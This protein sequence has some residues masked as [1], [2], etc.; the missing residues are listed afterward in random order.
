L[1]V[2]VAALRKILG[3]KK[4]EHRFIVTVPGKGYKFVADVA[5]SSGKENEI[6]IDSH[7][8]SRVLIEED[9]VE[10]SD[11]E[12][13]AEKIISP[14]PTLEKHKSGK[15]VS[16]T[17]LF[18]LCSSLVLVLTAFLAGIWFWE[19]GKPTERKQFSIVKLTSSGK[20][21][22]AAMTPDGK[23]AVFSQTEEAGESLWLRH[24]DTGSQTQ[25]VPAKAIKYV[26]LTTSPDGNLI[27]A[28]V[29]GGGMTDPQIWRLP[30]L[31]DSVEEMKEIKTGATVSLSPDGN[32]FAFTESRSALKE[33]HFGIADSN[34][35]NKRILI[36]GADDRRSFPNFGLTPVAWSPDGG[37]IA[38][39]V[40]EKLADGAKKSGILLVNPVDGGERFVSEKRWDYIA[41]LAWVD[42]DTLA[43]TAYQM[44]SR[45]GQIWILL[46]HFR[47]VTGFRKVISERFQFV[48]RRS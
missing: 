21:S 19:S 15:P 7:E 31:G 13:R 16:K 5:D 24:V 28:T 18:I 1:T 40:E 25:I 26:G 9:V 10:R 2:H 8:F 22:N 27:Y 44:N 38:C 35:T 46:P 30:L 29:F 47:Q 37:E 34:G 32:R 45:Q 4:C 6:I 20:I 42:G 39:I 12:I 33:T 17:S 36:R 48:G 14:H 3:E 23:Y 43:F 41:H 11:D